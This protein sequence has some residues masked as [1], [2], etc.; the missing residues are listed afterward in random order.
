MNSEPWGGCDVFIADHDHGK[1]GLSSQNQL[2]VDVKWVNA[3]T[4]L[5]VY[6]QH[7]RIFKREAKVRGVSVE[8]QTRD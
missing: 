7:A 8:Y 4:L 3:T 2:S 6:P 5:I 1:V